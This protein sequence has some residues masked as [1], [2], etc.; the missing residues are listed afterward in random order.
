MD[1][2]GSWKMSFLF[3]DSAYFQVLLLLVLGRVISHYKDPQKR[4]V[5]FHGYVVMSLSGFEPRSDCG[6]QQKFQ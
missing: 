1:G 4:Q 2:K 3:G 5:V 6:E